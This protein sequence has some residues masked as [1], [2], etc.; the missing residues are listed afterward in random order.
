[1]NHDSLACTSRQDGKCVGQAVDTYDRSVTIW[2]EPWSGQEL[3]LVGEVLN[4]FDI[5]P[6]HHNKPGNCNQS[7][8]IM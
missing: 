2:V 3:R 6:I 5:L 8:L 1:M 7:E 4:V